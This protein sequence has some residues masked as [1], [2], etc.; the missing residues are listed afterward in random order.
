MQPFEGELSRRG[1]LPAARRIVVAKPGQHLYPAPSPA[2]KQIRC[3]DQVTS[4]H[5]SALGEV[6]EAGEVKTGQRSRNVA[7]TAS[8]QVVRTPRS[9]P[10][11]PISNSILPSS[12]GS[13]TSR[14]Q[15]R[16]TAV[17]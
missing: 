4:F 14:S 10:S 7:A 6:G 17:S 12:V 3:R 8:Q 13:T 9:R 1:N 15:V 2:A 16:A 11:S 5:E